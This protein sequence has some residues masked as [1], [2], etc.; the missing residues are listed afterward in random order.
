LTP[1]SLDEIPYEITDFLGNVK[2][3][4]FPRQGHTSDVGII[5]SERGYFVLKRTKGEQYCSW[6]SKE[7][8]VLNCIAPTK[9]PIPT[10]FQFVEQQTE[11][12]AW[13]L[14]EFFEGETLRQALSNEKNRNKKL[15]TI[16]NFGAIL[17]QIHSTPCPK[18]LIR[19]SVWLDEMLRQAEVNLNNFKIDGT[20]DLLERLK[21]NKPT[22]IENTLI[23]GDF[24]I[25]N[26]LVR[27]GEITSII[28]WSGGALGDPRYDVSL[29]MRSK[30]N[31]FE[32]ETEVRTFFEG[33]GMRIIGE[34]E[35]KYFVDGLYEFF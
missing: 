7:I 3:I 16:F 35:Y 5:Q 20:A 33:Y 11:N 15:E 25:D 28:D 32:N 30:A 10:V 17:F 13:A 24:T 4:M 14:M 19:N 23:H 21:D 8:H 31:V 18:G 9:L 6:L 12:Q 29:A 2:D 26:V 34:R 22:P 27:D 1:L